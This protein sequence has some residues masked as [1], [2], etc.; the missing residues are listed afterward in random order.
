MRTYSK[1]TRGI[2]PAKLY[3]YSDITDITIS[4]YQDGTDIDILDGE[5]TGDDECVSAEF[6]AALFTALEKEHKKSNHV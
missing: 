4:V 1:L 6:F 5:V 3:S 2:M